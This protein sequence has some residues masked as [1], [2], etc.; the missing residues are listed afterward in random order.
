MGNSIYAKL[1]KTME[2]DGVAVPAVLYDIPEGMSEKPGCDKGDA[3][4]FKLIHFS[5]EILPS[6]QRNELLEALSENLGKSL[7]LRLT[8]SLALM[9]GAYREQLNYLGLY[10]ILEKKGKPSR[11]SGRI[12]D[13]NKRTFNVGSSIINRY[14]SKFEDLSQT[15]YYLTELGR[16]LSLDALTLN[17]RFPNADRLLLRDVISTHQAN[18]E[19]G[20]GYNDLYAYILGNSLYPAY[21]G[22]DTEVVV[23][24]GDGSHDGMA[25]SYFVADAAVKTF[26]NAKD[27]LFRCCQQDYI[28]VDTG[29]QNIDV[30]ADKLHRYSQMVGS[31]VNDE[32]IPLTELIFL[33]H[34]HGLCSSVGR[35][36]IND[37]AFAR[38]INHSLSD[39]VMI[40]QM[41]QKAYYPGENSISSLYYAIFNDNRMAWVTT[42]DN[43]LLYNSA[44][45]IR[46]QALSTLNRL[47]IMGFGSCSID[48]LWSLMALSRSDSAVS[49]YNVKYIRYSDIYEKRKGVLLSEAVKCLKTSHPDSYRILNQLCFKGFSVASC[50]GGDMYRTYF[51]LHPQ[52][53]GCTSCLLE[54]LA[55]NKYLDRLNIANARF[56]PFIELKDDRHSLVLKNALALKDGSVICIEDI[57]ADYGSRVRCSSFISSYSWSLASADIRRFTLCVICDDECSAYNFLIKHCLRSLDNRSLA[58]ADNISKCGDVPCNLPLF[59]PRGLLLAHMQGFNSKAGIFTFKS[60]NAYM[61]LRQAYNDNNKISGSSFSSYFE[62]NISSDDVQADLAYF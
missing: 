58:S 33:S 22:F 12:Y 55:K 54:V 8:L 3:F 11:C 38:A 49:A 60:L 7:S 57:D 31:R 59:I 24:Y 19:H 44:A 27:G 47:I 56:A 25:D 34:P 36:V 15:Y 6:A 20:S 61:K 37:D 28:E 17:G 4:L 23:N 14:E 1:A 45:S 9:G 43:G 39:D 16:E 42:P 2:N 30:I 52:F 32:D 50:F 5:D 51:T 53:T 41:L 62:K 46:T 29:S 40:V 18:L 10:D 13:A 35:L 21:F 48:A 26:Y